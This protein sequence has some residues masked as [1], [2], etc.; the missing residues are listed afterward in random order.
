MCERRKG[1]KKKTFEFFGPK[2]RIGG[3]RFRESVF[4]G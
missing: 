2:V 1:R 4:R 3:R